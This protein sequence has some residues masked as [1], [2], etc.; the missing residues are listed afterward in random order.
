MIP[1]GFT[2]LKAIIIRQEGS[3]ISPIQFRLVR[4]IINMAPAGLEIDRKSWSTKM[5]LDVIRPVK[6]HLNLVTE[7]R[8]DIG[9]LR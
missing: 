9:N 3:I 4:F 2:E 8:V 5:R 7:Q 6:T 1:T